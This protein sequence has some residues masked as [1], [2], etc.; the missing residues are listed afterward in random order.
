MGG[1]DARD[2]LAGRHDELREQ[3]DRVSDPDADRIEAPGLTRLVAAHISS[4]Q[5]LVV[6]LLKSKGIGDRRLFRRLKSEY[7]RMT[8]SRCGS[9]GGKRTLL[10]SR[11]P[12]LRLTEPG[13]SFE[14][15]VRG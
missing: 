5:S 13:G 12:G 7:R 4:E 15:D 2:F 8:I 10:T 14:R 11:C 3:F 9:S 6:P 1:T